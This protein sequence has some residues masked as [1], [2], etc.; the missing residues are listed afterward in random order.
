MCKI[1]FYRIN[2]LLCPASSWK[3]CVSVATDPVYMNHN[4]GG[5]DVVI[6]V[7]DS[8]HF[9]IKSLFN[10][11]RFGFLVHSS[12]IQSYLTVENV[13]AAAEGVDLNV[14]FVWRCCVA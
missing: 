11:T 10:A 14:L 5:D 4:D 9:F 1:F 7:V 2:A 8:L 3:S 12:T 6:N 13:L